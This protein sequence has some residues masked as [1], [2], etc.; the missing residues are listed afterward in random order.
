[1]I[2]KITQH[3]KTLIKRNLFHFGLIKRFTPPEGMI[4]FGDL[5]RTKSF[6][7]K[8]GYDRGG[9][10]DRYYIEGFLERESECIRGAVIEIKDRA[11]TMQFGGSKVG[12][13]EILDIDQD[14]SSAT[15]VADLS[16]APNLPDNTYDCLIV[17]QTLQLIY[18]FKDALR[19]CHRILK[20][21]GTLLLTVPGITPIDHK[22]LGDTWFWSFTNTA[23]KRIMEE[24]FPGGR[25]EVTS[26]GNV[27]AATAFL[28]GL[29]R[30]ELTT[31]QL[32]FQDP[33]MQ[34]IITVKAT[35][36]S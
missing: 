24:T 7:K 23:M 17:T 28:Y 1:M 22:L 35:R 15:I 11:Y 34:V 30:T 16:N 13:S 21:G 12:K 29:G 25:A 18:D 32:D 27:L 14:N 8:F 10:V 36:N 20:P 6:S 33:N 31:E 26:Y 3:A 19:T 4:H 5:N 9:P 2:R